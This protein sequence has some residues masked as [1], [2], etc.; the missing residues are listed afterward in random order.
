MTERRDADRIHPLR[1][2]GGPAG[3]PRRLVLGV[4]RPE[5]IVPRRTRWRPV[6]D[7]EGTD[8]R[9]VAARY[10]KLAVRYEATVLVAAIN[11]WL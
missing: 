10:D 9:A 2:G 4:V 11:E 1:R 6:A 5:Q 7:S 3:D 8:H